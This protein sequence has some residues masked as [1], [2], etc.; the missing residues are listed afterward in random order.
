MAREHVPLVAFNRGIISPLALARTDIRRTALSAEEQ[1]NWMPRVLGSMMLR[2]GLGY[3]GG[4]KSNNKAFH[5]PFIFSTTDTAII[6]ITDANMRVYVDD[7]VVTRNSV[8]TAITDDDFS[9]DTGAWVD[10]DEVGATSTIDTTDE[11]LELVGS[12]YAA[13]GR[14]QTIAVADGDQNT[15]HAVRIEVDRGPVTFRLGST[16][17][18]DE[19]ISETTLGTGTHSL[20][21]TPTTANIYLQ[22]TSLAQAVKIVSSVEIEASNGMDITAPWAEA[23]LQNIRYDQSADVIYIACNGYKPKK[24]ERR[25]ARSWSLVDY[26]PEDGPFRVLNTGV[27][28]LTP[29]AISGD[30]TLAASRNLFTEDH[31][32]AL[33]KITSVGQL[34]EQDITG[35]DQWS[36]NIRVIGTGTQRYFDIVRAG[37]WVGT[38]TLQRSVDEPG[39]WVD[40]AT[41]TTNGTVTNYNDGLSNQIV[42][43]RIGI[44]AGDYTSGTAELSMT[45]ANGNLTGVVRITAYTDEQNVSAAVL[46]SLGGTDASTNWYEGEWSDY[47]GYPSSTVLHEGRNWWAG[48][49]KVWGSISDAYE[50]FDEEQEG[51]SAPINRSIGQGPVDSVDWLLP[52]SRLIIG[53]DGAEWSARSSSLDEPLTV[54]N[55]NLKAPSTQ[56]SYNV[57]AVKIDDTGLFVQR[58]G[59]KLFQLNT[60]GDVTFGDY[61]SVDL[62]EL[63]PEVGEPSI[64]RIMPQRQPDTRVHCV[65]SDGKVAVL[66][67]QPAEEVLCWVLV[68]TDGDI[69]DVVVLPGSVEDVVYYVVKRTI[70]GSTVRYLEKW[71]LESECRGGALNKQADSFIVYDDVSTTTITG[72]S[73]LE[74]EE[75]I[76]WADG[77]YVGTD[78]VSGGQI[79][80]TTAASQV[81]VGVYYEARFKSAKLAYA[82]RLGTALTQK[83]KVDHI[84]LMLYNT[85]YQGLRYGPSFEESGGEYT[86]LDGLPAVEEGAEVADDTVWESYDTE[87]IEFNGE[88]DTDSRVCLLAQ[89]PK[90]CT[91]L[92]AVIAI[93]TNG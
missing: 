54:S 41:Y 30:I 69:E 37:T 77:I 39:S 65:R 6:E 43:Y 47:R 33:Y 80:L 46:S 53:T 25:A 32:G 49:T 40:V 70:N 5:I 59:T 36:D 63:A 31:V 21:F 1:T 35:E 3:I 7:T 4:T 60:S 12:G 88:W 28:T 9:T 56:G 74:A 18:G 55:F 57:A 44:K 27:T 38:V 13:A 8:S 20:A 78:T 34:V 72:L 84:G 45:Y 62:M 48:K 24:I 73:H 90:P 22:I 61:Q 66:I 50:S 81:V 86:L 82:S 87:M 2:P 64:I 15:E 93:N 11:Q 26:E 75:V 17:G 16:S 83:K 19:L 92:G 67:S 29:S 42:Y 89:A 23:D 51:D 76:I 52:L 71:A 79:T 58:S 85:H 91:V 10:I 68:E 14:R